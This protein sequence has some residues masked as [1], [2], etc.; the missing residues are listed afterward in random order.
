MFLDVFSSTSRYFNDD[1]TITYSFVCVYLN[2]K[3]CLDIGVCLFIF[4]SL[5][6]QFEHSA[7]QC[8]EVVTYQKRNGFCRT[9]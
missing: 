6:V 2:Y 3:S 5:L 1:Q 4:I 8:G 9:Y 7:I